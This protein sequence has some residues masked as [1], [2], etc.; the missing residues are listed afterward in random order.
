M[1]KVPC[2]YCSAA[3]EDDE[4]R[5]HRCGRRLDAAPQRSRADSYVQTNL[6]LATDS[7]PAEGEVRRPAAVRQAGPQAVPAP[8][9]RRPSQGEPRVQ[10][11]LFGPQAVQPEPIVYDVQIGA[12]TPTITP[13]ASAAAGPRLERPVQH[14]LDFAA[15]LPQPSRRLETPVEPA[16]YC[17]APVAIIESRLYACF[18]DFAVPQIGLGFFLLTIGVL[19][20]EAKL[21]SYAPA[22]LLLPTALLGIF[23]R[24]LFCL[25]DRDTL[26]VQWAGLRILHFDGRRP[27]RRER[28]SRLA[29]GCLSAIACG[30]GLFWA[31][32]DEEHLTWHDRISCTFPTPVDTDG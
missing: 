11:S 25:G 10:G 24:L 32:F 20:P 13:R 30:L 3:N 18:F 16:I 19:L 23:Y 9:G 12:P 2:H 5:C 17:T 29:S 22:H 21:A 8:Q 27:T 26:G 1:K 28:F 7:W 4:H 6:A 31:L 15:P 14:R